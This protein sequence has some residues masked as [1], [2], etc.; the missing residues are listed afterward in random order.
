[1]SMKI[2]SK[3]IPHNVMAGRRRS[4]PPDGTG[5]ENVELL[6]ATTAAE[7][8]PIASA[9][10]ILDAKG[11]GFGDLRFKG[12]AEPAPLDAL[13]RKESEAI[14]ALAEVKQTR[15]EQRER[16][17]V[18]NEQ[19][20]AE[21]ALVEPKTAKLAALLDAVLLVLLAGGAPDED[22]CL[23][24]VAIEQELKGATGSHDVARR[25]IRQ[26]RVGNT[27][28]YLVAPRIALATGAQMPPLF[29]APPSSER[30]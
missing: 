26:H 19:R 25:I 5:L 14:A 6:A 23:R 1:M 20:A 21:K 22:W 9:F 12:P 2:E 29:T 16:L 7:P 11:R 13:T 24:M 4:A 30:E 17:R 3:E 15:E 28:P 10:P 18:L 27:Y 8:E